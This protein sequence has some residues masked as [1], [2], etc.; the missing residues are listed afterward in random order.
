M[1]VITNFGDVSTQG[2]TTMTGN[3]TV[4]GTGTSSWTSAQSAVTLAGTLSVTGT[5]TTTGVVYPLSDGL[6]GIG[7]PAR[8]FNNVF[9]ANANVYSTANIATANVSNLNVFALATFVGPVTVQSTTLLIGTANIIAPIVPGSA[10]TSGIGTVALPFA[11]AF[12]ST[13]NIGSTTPQLSLNVLGNTFISNTLNVTNVLGVTTNMSYMNVISWMNIATI[14]VFTGANVTT[15]TVSGLSNLA[16]ANI[17]SS[18]LQTTNIQYANVATINV[19]NA[20]NITTLTVSGLTNLF[21]S[22]LITAN[23]ESSNTQYANIRTLNV[24]AGANI[25]TLTVSGLSNLFNANI[26]SSNL[27]TT[28]IQ[29]ANVATINVT[30]AANITTLTVSGLSN[31]FNANIVS[32]NLQTTNI[33]YANVATIN[34][35]NAANITTLTVS[36]LSNLFNANI[37]SS[38][39]QTTNIQYANVATINVTN[40]ANITTLTVSGLSNLFN[41]NIVSSNL[42]TTNIQYANVATINVTN[43]INVTTLTVSTFENVISSNIV[44]LVNSTLNVST[45]ANIQV[46]NIFSGNVISTWN[47]NGLLSAR[48]F[49]GNGSAL[50]NLHASNISNGVLNFNATNGLGANGIAISGVLGGNGQLLA[51]TGGVGAGVQWIGPATGIWSNVAPAINP[52]PYP[53]Y[54]SIGNV[55]VGNTLWTSFGTGFNTYPGAPLD[56]YG[57]SGTFSNVSD[58]TYYGTIRIQNNP[59]THNAPGGLEFKCGTTGVPGPGGG[60]GH[61]LVA[62]ELSVGSGVAPL[63]WQVR[64]G[65]SVW[66]NALTVMCGSAYSRYVGIGTE[67]PLYQVHVY[68]SSATALATLTVQHTGSNQGS[69]LYL[70]NSSG[71]AATLFLNGPT[72]TSDGP[73]NSATLRNDAGDLRVMGRNNKPMIYLDSVSNAVIFGTTTAVASANV[74]VWAPQTAGTG[75]PMAIAGDTN[76]GRGNPGSNYA[77]DPGAGQLILTGSTNTN[78]RL[79]LMY[80][81]TNNIGLIQAMING[82]GASA[83]ML[84]GAGGN[85]GVGKTSASYQL[86]VNGYIRANSLCLVG[87]LNVVNRRPIW[88]IGSKAS[89]KYLS[90]AYSTSPVTSSVICYTYGAFQY[91]VPAVATGATRYYR[92]YAC[93]NDNATTGT[94]SIVY[95]FNTGGS[96]TFTFNNTYGGA[97]SSYDRDYMSALVADPSNGNHGYWTVVGTPSALGVGASNPFNIYF[98]YIELQAIDQY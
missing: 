22:N 98:N 97:D 11:N 40:A 3:V 63:I 96:V 25:T 52:P 87:Y 62:S 77:G 18:N 13:A 83:L 73:A 36:G 90:L 41:A 79:G 39:L 31:L 89:A 47:V 86:D 27:Q 59:G 32:S 85:V 84:N 7:G 50:M 60:S 75:F 91:A 68:Q 46:T 30:N 23:M 95:N 58:S 5:T 92:L 4:Q 54:Y 55:G 26:V 81:T 49:T 76:L 10:T 16:T 71:V 56:V 69:Y 24:W 14:N 38:N 61:R 29:Y 17:V 28:N 21:N 53:I 45:Q 88:G 48:F 33:Q 1:P 93:Y 44:T 65:T 6:S 74:T 66:S 43:A 72:S 15:L 8:R 35:T 67:G 57:G 82:T 70:S 34:V 19:W 51:S 78:K 12:L 64:S 2:N 94:F 20:A 9:T 42:Q 37:V 80:D